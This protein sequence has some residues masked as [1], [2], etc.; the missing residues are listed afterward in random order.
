M[1]LYAFINFLLFFIMKFLF[2]LFLFL[3]WQSIK[4][5]KK[6]LTNQKKESV[7]RNCQWNCMNWWLIFSVKQR[8]LSLSSKCIFEKFTFAVFFACKLLIKFFI[9]SKLSAIFLD[10]WQV[11]ILFVNCKATFSNLFSCELVLYLS[12]CVFYHYDA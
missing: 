5:L 2:S 1:L 6:I 10:Q 11:S 3:F 9:E 8:E 12:N 7:V 4:F